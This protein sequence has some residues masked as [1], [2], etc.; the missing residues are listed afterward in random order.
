MLEQKSELVKDQIKRGPVDKA[1]EE[2][3]E[4]KRLMDGVW[5]N[6]CVLQTLFEYFDQFFFCYIFNV[7]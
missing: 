2:A 6:A 1:A 7:S 4:E 5:A 3:E